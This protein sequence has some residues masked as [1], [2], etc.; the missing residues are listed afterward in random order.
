MDERGKG[1]GGSLRPSTG[2]AGEASEHGVSLLE[3]DVGKVAAVA[4]VQRS[5]ARLNLPGSSTSS[6]ASSSAS[7]RLTKSSSVAA[8]SAIV[9]LPQSSARRRRT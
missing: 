5:A 7:G 6:R 4:G 8:A 2:K 1:S 3:P 9:A